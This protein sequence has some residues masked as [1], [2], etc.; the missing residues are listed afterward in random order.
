M[1][2]MTFGLVDDAVGLAIVC[3]PDG[4][5]IPNNASRRIANFS[6]AVGLAQ[7]QWSIKEADQALGVRIDYSLDNGETWTEL[8]PAS[9]SSGISSAHQKSAQA[10]IP[11][12]VAAQENGVL[13]RAVA[14]GPVDA[15]QTFTFIT[16]VLS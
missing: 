6:F 3:N 10:Q 2:Y 1:A 11:T 15:I 7:I 8:I 12:V 9:Y 4:V 13:C 5:E 14:V 16:L